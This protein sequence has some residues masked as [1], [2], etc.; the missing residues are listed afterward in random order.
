M[1]LIV[2]KRFGKFQGRGEKREKRLSKI[3]GSMANPCAMNKTVDTICMHALIF[4]YG[5]TKLWKLRGPNIVPG[6]YACWFR[7]KLVV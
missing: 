5:F 3:N 7:A 2:E 6:H 4:Q 1:R